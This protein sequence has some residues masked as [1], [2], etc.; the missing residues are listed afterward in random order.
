MTRRVSYMLLLAWSF[1]TV[2]ECKLAIL[3]GLVL[4]V[5]LMYRLTLQ[6][7]AINGIDNYLTLLV[8]VT[9]TY[10]IIILN[11]VIIIIIII[12][13]HVR[14]KQEV[15]GGWTDRLLLILTKQT[16]C[17]PIIQTK[18]HCKEAFESSKRVWKLQQ[19]LRHTGQ[20]KKSIHT[21]PI[22]YN[23]R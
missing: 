7:E 13:T 2:L 17:L 19:S 14:C 9:T 22:P 3:G 18:Q 6:A 11:L 10:L 5:Y 12:I 4:A 23:K 20:P 8:S 1:G 15:P 16:T 21:P